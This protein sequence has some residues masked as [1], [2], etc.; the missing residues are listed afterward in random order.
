MLR[1]GSPDPA[2]DG[3]AEGIARQHCISD[4]GSARIVQHLMKARPASVRLF[5]VLISWWGCGPGLVAAPVAGDFFDAIG[6]AP[7][8]VARAAGGSWLLGH[9]AVELVGVPMSPAHRA[10]LIEALQAL[11]GE[12][13]QITA[14]R[15]LIELLE[16]DGRYA[17][18]LAVVRAAGEPWRVREVGLQWKS[19]DL[20]AA[21]AAI[22]RAPGGSCADWLR[23]TGVDLAT[24]KVERALQMLEFLEA[25][26]AVPPGARHALALHHLEL[27]RRQGRAE[28]LIQATA[29]PTLR[30][31][32]QVA[33]GQR[34][35]ALAG[36][37]PDLKP[38]L[39]DLEL[40]LGAVGVQPVLLAAARD[41]LADPQLDATRKAGLISCFRDPSQRF[42]LWC[43]LPIGQADVL[44][45]LGYQLGGFSGQVPESARRSLGEVM[46]RQ[47]ADARLELLAARIDPNT[48]A[49]G[50]AHL[51]R[52]AVDFKE[53]AGKRIGRAN[54]YSDPAATALE[55][56]VP[57]STAAELDGLLSGNP[58]FSRLPLND[59]LRYLMAAQLDRRVAA[60]LADWQPAPTFG[61]ATESLIPDYV[62]RQAA[63]RVIPAEVVARLLEIFPQIN[64]NP[65]AG[66]E[67]RVGDL[68]RVWMGTLT[69]L[70]V[71]D[72]ELA[73]AVKALVAKAQRPEVA[74]AVISGIPAPV[75]AL[76]GIEAPPRAAAETSMA[77][78][79]WLAALA[80][81]TPEI[82]QE[83]K[84]PA[85]QS[86]WGSVAWHFQL[87]PLQMGALAVLGHSPW[88]QSVSAARLMHLSGR[89]P[90]EDLPAKLRVLFAE[91]A[92]RTLMYDL[93]VATHELDCYDDA[94]RAQADRRAAA[95][96]TGPADDPAIPMYLLVRRMVGPTPLEGASIEVGLSSYLLATRIRLVA[97][98]QL[99]RNFVNGTPAL[100]KL[101]DGQLVKPPQAAPV[102]V[103]PAAPTAR[104]RLQW[105]IEGKKD[106]TPECLE[107]ASTIVSDCANAGAGGSWD[108]VDRAVGVLVK[109]KSWQPFLADLRKRME[110]GGC[111]ELE[112]RRFLMRVHLYPGVFPV[113]AA[114]LFAKQVL[115]LDPIDTAAAAEALGAAVKA[116]DREATLRYLGI[117][118]HHSRGRFLQA[119]GPRRGGGFGPELDPLE[120]FTGLHVAALV[121]HLLSEPLA[122]PDVTS[123]GYFGGA[124]QLNCQP[125]SL[126]LMAHDPAGLRAVMRWAGVLTPDHGTELLEIADI[127]KRS[128]EPQKAV[129][130]L[131]EAFFRAVPAVEDLRFPLGGE[132]I[133]LN[134]S[135]FSVVAL[136]TGGWLK[137]LAEKADAFPVSSATAGIRLLIQLAVDPRM[138]TWNRLVPPFLAS[139]PLARRSQI[140][141]RLCALLSGLPQAN[142]LLGQLKRRDAIATNRPPTLRS[143]FV[144]LGAAADAG[145]A[146]LA[147]FCWQTAGPLLAKAKADE[148]LWFLSTVAKPILSL[149][150]EPLWRGFLERA[151]QKDGFADAWLG[152]I[153][154]N[155]IWKLP[156]LR[157][158]EVLDFFISRLQPGS[159][160]GGELVA[161]FNAVL[162]AEPPDFALLKRLLPWV[163]PKD[164]ATRNAGGSNSSLQAYEVLTGAPAAVHP[165]GFA[166]MESDTGCRVHWSLVGFGSRSANPL[167]LT[168]LAAFDGGFDLDFLVGPQADRLQ[169][170]ETR[171]QAAAI[172]ST[173]LQVPPGTKFVA[174]LARQRGGSVIRWSPALAIADLR[175]TER[176]PLTSVISGQPP[177][178]VEAKITES[179]GPF[180]QYETV[181]FTV[182]P[183]VTLEIARFAWSGGPAPEIFGWLAPG[184]GIGQLEMSYQ[185]AQGKVLG[186]DGIEPYHLGT[187]LLATWQRFF[188]PANRTPPSATEVIVL[189]AR[190]TSFEQPV[191]LRMA[192]LRWVPSMALDS[193]APGVVPVGRIPGNFELL[194]QDERGTTWAISSAD[195]GVGVFD[196]TNGRFS[197]WIPLPS[198]AVAVASNYLLWLAMA[199]DLIV[200]IDNTGALHQVSVSSR[201]VTLHEGPPEWAAS[202]NDGRDLSHSVQLSP[203][204]K[205][206][207]WTGAEAGLFVA[208][209]GPAGLSTSRLL[210]TG[211]VQR[212]GFDLQAGLLRVF[213]DKQ[214]HALPLANWRTADLVAKPLP[215]VDPTNDAKWS[216]ETPDEG[217]IDARRDVR[218]R[219]AFPSDGENSAVRLMEMEP[220]SRT[221]S[222]PEGQMRF[223]RSDTP[224]FVTP[225]GRV[226]RVETEHIRGFVPTLR[227]PGDRWGRRG[228]Y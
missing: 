38:D 25:R 165:Q 67:F 111:S 200:C 195:H 59:R 197:G 206:L 91:N 87:K 175:R 188:T 52:A 26:S 14:R 219:I 162:T 43:G 110:Q 147:T 66:E 11:A 13:K 121:R 109:A 166:T 32:W 183:K 47:P 191:K 93:L 60:A 122:P 150:D 177:V 119:I 187:S 168:N 20:K 103:A 152:E 31:V 202:P 196:P 203:D 12:P 35:Q 105:F 158:A 156:V 78:P 189:V 218:F 136:E 1:L 76:A 96:V 85:S 36:L 101:I 127:F 125:L 29:S 75:R 141:A 145:D 16:E 159:P 160:H 210:E 204:G 61:N 155:G 215:R 50:K 153:H 139:Q 182:P 24:G 128:D 224:Y 171:E 118:A 102:P 112:I 213:D 63:R 99:A 22:Q 104:E 10:E 180:G 223:D 199:G 226:F 148:Q 216:G 174:L 8:A 83:E 117:L 72:A 149:G 120:L 217:G 54:A 178:P 3:L 6:Q 212:V 142:S 58:G 46:A 48:P 69:G 228:P 73:L 97:S 131:A 23:L 71:A 34:D 115:E 4:H 74:L 133:F 116:R 84:P 225:A 53:L 151:A 184:V 140:S 37:G 170:L 114:A 95:A 15:W 64:L 194:A 211:R 21:E 107:L 106:G 82:A 79:S 205:L 44:E 164:A 81:F 221:V 55:A 42:E 146:A 19:G 18:A 27:A 68:I 65:P 56:L 39:G 201:Q 7:A 62:G 167:V 5:A 186:R 94:L 89:A 9:G 86:G 227:P 80:I 138:E 214:Q 154:A 198:V 17:D 40:L 124:L 30:A 108:G 129:E 192:D 126:H 179:A 49:Q 90:G 169:L 157:R 92:P 113:G 57:L 88:V 132:D 173:T 123:G 185:T 143:L 70:P 176:V 222:M 28:A 137:P 220:L 41:F 33:L 2:H 207:V 134:E 208:Q 77:G 193:P 163:E 161:I 190:S 144:D 100:A 181:E 45:I 135:K 172:G 51:L 209:L 130:M 98:C